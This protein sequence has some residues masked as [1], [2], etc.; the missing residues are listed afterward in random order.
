MRFF[1]CPSMLRYGLRK[2]VSNR[3]N[4]ERLKRMHLQTGMFRARPLFPQRSIH[5]KN[6]TF[7][8]YMGFKEKKLRA[9]TSLV[10]PLQSFRTPLQLQP[11]PRL[12]KLCIIITDTLTLLNKRSELISNCRK[13][14]QT[15]YGLIY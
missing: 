5:R 14:T 11:V 8:A 7:P 1:L 9:D 3:K 2:P 15:S 6:G 10:H 12:I 4:L 13:L